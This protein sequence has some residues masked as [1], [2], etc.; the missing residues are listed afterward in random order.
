MKK[1]DIFEAITEIDDDVLAAHRQMDLRLSRKHSSKRYALRALA[2]AACLVLIMV[3]A[4]TVAALNH[5]VGQ[6]IM[7]KDSEAL[8]EYLLGIDGFAAWQEKTAE[9][10]E[11]RLPE[12]LWQMM[13]ST[14]ILDVL[15]QSQYPV[16]SWKNA[17]FEAFVQQPET[18]LYYLNDPTATIPVHTM[19]NIAPTQQQNKNA[20]LSYVLKVGETEHSLRY[21]YSES[22]S[23]VRQAVHVYAKY[24]EQGVYLAFLDEQTGE[25]VYWYSPERAEASAESG[26]SKQDMMDRSYEML[27]DKVRDP[28]AYVLK[29][30]TKQ[31]H[32]TVYVY[33]YTRVISLF[34]S[35]GASELLESTTVLCCDKATFL[36]DAA[37]NMV[38]MDLCYLGAL[39]AIA[40]QIP[41]EAVAWALDCTQNA[42][43]KSTH[44]VL[45]SEACVVIT[46]DGRLALTMG[47]S[48]EPAAEQRAEYD[49]IAYLTEQNVD[50]GDLSYVPEQVISALR[51]Y[52][53]QLIY[54][55]SGS[56]AVY[57][58]YDQYGREIRNT[59]QEGSSKKTVVTSAYDEQGRL[60]EEITVVTDSGKG[61]VG[62]AIVRYTYN[63][64][65]QLILCETYDGQE[66]LL[67]FE[68]Y[69]YDEQGRLIRKEE[70]H[71]VSTYTYTDDNHYTIKYESPEGGP[72]ER[73]EVTCDDQGNILIRLSYI[74]DQ[75]CR[76]TLYDANGN[77]LS[78]TD[79]TDGE[80]TDSRR[81]EYDE[82]NRLI[83]QQNYKNGNFVTVLEYVYWENDMVSIEIEFFKGE[84]NWYAG[85]HRNHLG[86]FVFITGQ[87]GSVNMFEYGFINP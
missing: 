26:A 35:A 13:Q 75:L 80:M 2:I 24:S 57:Y 20:P 76:E 50:F 40:D 30:S 79:Y 71:S 31:D 36:F 83:K 14:P 52:E 55:N 68:R 33:E 41:R 28:E 9:E 12:D 16:Y 45:D 39:R 19:I 32:G 48:C 44:A 4:L 85:K 49:C 18:Y 64:Q 58:E 46:P 10:L 15:T 65:G 7:Q 82:Q 74:N 51:V 37:G 54:T 60:I 5:P 77:R 42:V 22:Q 81:Y 17:V 3:V 61:Y 38:S 70:T 63:E 53:A 67:L 87:S 84:L 78:Y 6:A 72:E 23:I 25:C 29:V 86:E 62:T 43:P 11:Q 59:K 8:S 34:G 69:E 66:V 73:D 27:G 56:Q 21:V 1:E 47:A